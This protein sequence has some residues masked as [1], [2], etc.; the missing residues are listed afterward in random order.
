MLEQQPKDGHKL[1]NERLLEISCKAISFFNAFDANK[2][3]LNNSP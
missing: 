3:I 1:Q 2:K